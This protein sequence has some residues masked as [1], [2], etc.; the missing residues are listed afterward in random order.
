MEVIVTGF[1]FD[2][3]C[4]SST[5]ITNTIKNSSIFIT[6]YR[7]VI[8]SFFFTSTDR[9]EEHP[10][11]SGAN[12]IWDKNTLLAYL[13]CPDETISTISSFVMFNWIILSCNPR[14]R[15]M[16]E[17]SSDLVA[18]HFKWCLSKSNT[19]QTFLE[20]NFFT[21]RASARP[22]HCLLKTRLRHVKWMK[23]NFSCKDHACFRHKSKLKVQSDIISRFF[24]RTKKMIN[25][26]R[27]N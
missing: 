20:L 24:A 10:T 7:F 18:T 11:F 25:K 12:F 22:L 27:L 19:I 15:H 21:L 6:K 26:N 5:F 17:R 23:M 3:T 13:F 1:S 8:N 4:L 14:A 2:Q 9:P 16:M